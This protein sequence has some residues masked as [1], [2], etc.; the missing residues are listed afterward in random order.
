MPSTQNPTPILPSPLCVFPLSDQPS[1]CASR[2]F[3]PRCLVH[4]VILTKNESAAEMA[5][6]LRPLRTRR[7]LRVS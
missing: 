5:P 4:K 7:L 6:L 3:L 1:D 2:C